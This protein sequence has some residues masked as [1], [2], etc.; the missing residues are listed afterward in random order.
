MCDKRGFSLIEVLVVISIVALMTSILIP[1]LDKA[2]AQAIQTTC[3]SNLHQWGIIF[4]MFAIENDNQFMERG[5]GSS[6]GAVSWFH[7]VRNFYDPNDGMLFCPEAKRT[8]KQGGTN[9][10]MAWDNTTD[11]GEYYSGSYGIN[12]YVA[13]DNDPDFWGTINA[14]NASEVPLLMCNQWKDMQPFASDQPHEYESEIWT[15]GPYN[16]MRRPCIKRHAP[17]HVN[18]LFLDFAVGK[19]TIKQLWRLKW[20]RNWPS[21]APLP[22]WPEWMSDVPEP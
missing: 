18:F 14:K 1:A 19:R 21:D 11:F 9:P 3:T 15:V 10:R 16:E 8:I 12:L 2:K 6:R 13:I 4:K 5:R 7:S 22:E 20:S 17:Y